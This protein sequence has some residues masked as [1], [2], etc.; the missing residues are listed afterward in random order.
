MYTRKGW[1]GP[2][3]HEIRERRR[4]SKL[5][6]PSFLIAP[7]G[8]F[9]FPSNVDTSLFVSAGSFEKKKQTRNTRMSCFEN[10]VI[11]LKYEKIYSIY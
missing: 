7:I 5:T 11:F 10:Y 4:Q 1:E 2:A 8:S 3:R 6:R 9:M